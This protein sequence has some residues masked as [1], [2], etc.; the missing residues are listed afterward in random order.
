V[1]RK[2][3]LAG[4]A[5]FVLLTVGVILRLGVVA[6]TPPLTDDTGNELPGSIAALEKLELGGLDQWVLIRGTDRSNPVLLW[7][8]GG[9]GGAQMPFAHHLDRELEQH[10]VVVHWDQ[11]GAGKS[12]HGR[13]DEET[14]RVER[15]LEDA[16]ELIEYLRRRLDVE[17]IVL[18]GH[19]WGTRLGIHLVDRYPEYFDAYVGVSQTVNHDRAT[20]IAHEW[21]SRAI[22]PQQAPEDWQTLQEIDVPAR[23]HVEFRRL[24]SLAEAHGGSLDLSVGELARI[25]IRAPEYTAW[26]YVR[27]LQGMNRGGG[28]MH[29]DGVMESF[30]FIEAIPALDV[31]VYFFAGA[32]DYNTPLALVE[33]Y[34]EILE[35]PAKELVVFERS[36]HTPFFAEAARFTAEVIRVAGRRA[37]E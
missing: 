26:D 36:A 28:P 32:N 21:L 22:D 30:D 37:L 29:E 8:H 2:L 20:V 10:F 17:R 11:R 24:N 27:L 7:L 4:L 14:M 3:L 18:L 5:V 9:P 19:S 35:A 1:L 33:E 25:A 31:P 15:Y 16:C 12:N 6:H 23:R 13:F 34:Y